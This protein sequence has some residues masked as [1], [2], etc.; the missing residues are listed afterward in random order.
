LAGGTRIAALVSTLALGAC[1]GGGSPPTAVAT[2]GAG[3]P[4]KV[5]QLDAGNFDALALADGRVALVEFHS[6]T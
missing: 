1:G 2:P 3:D 4:G 5:V 6:P